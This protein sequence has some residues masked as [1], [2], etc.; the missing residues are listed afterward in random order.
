MRKKFLIQLI[1]LLIF[2]FW[3]GF[4]FYKNLNE[5]SQLKV[6][7]P[8][9]FFPLSLLLVLF[10]ATNGLVLKYLLEPFNIKLKFKEWFGLS[11]INSMGNYLTPFK[12]GAVVRAIY[13]KKLHKFSYSHFLSTLAGIYIIVFLVNSFIGILTLILLQYFLGIFNLLIFTIF[14]VLFLLL[15]TLI[16]FSPKVKETKYYFVNKLVSVINGWHLI[17]SNKKSVFITIFVSLTNVLIIVFAMV[18]EFYIFGA[19]ISL[20]KA[21]F[22]SIVSSLSLFISIT[23]GS[24]GVKETLLMFTAETINVSTPQVLAISI[25]DRF[26]GLIIILIFG[27]IFSYI[28]F[29]SKDSAPYF[30]DSIKSLALKKIPRNGTKL[31]K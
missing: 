23:P 10:L 21:L 3:F 4:Y 6:V 12:G 26:V 28:L 18:L 27:S 20:L 24:L 25:L 22:L 16:I 17:K 19:K 11:V 8:I 13:L 29:K 9:Y 31:I 30:L 1:A 7:S 2:A 5:F 14:L 15:L